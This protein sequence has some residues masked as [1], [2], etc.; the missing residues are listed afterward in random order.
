[1]IDPGRGSA[2]NHPETLSEDRHLPYNVGPT[3]RLPK[4]R[5]ETSLSVD[6]PDHL[7]ILRD[8]ISMP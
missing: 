7:S 2:E 1:V 5:E 4:E 6:S 3:G 8:R